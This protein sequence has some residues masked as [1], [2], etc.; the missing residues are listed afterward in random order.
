MEF[1]RAVD[2]RTRRF[3]EFREKDVYWSKHNK[4]YRHWRSVDNCGG[5]FV[6][7]S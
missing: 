7:Y 6:V 2:R 4:T 5:D 3:R 1:N